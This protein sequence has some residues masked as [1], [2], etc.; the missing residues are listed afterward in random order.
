MLRLL[1]ALA[2]VDSWSFKCLCCIFLESIPIII[3]FILSLNFSVVLSHET[4]LVSISVSFLS[5]CKKEEVASSS[6]KKDIKNNQSQS[7][8]YSTHQ[9]VM[10][11]I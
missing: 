4:S 5:S 10:L 8:M 6:H 9:D 1:L 2:L 3:I 7:N 11:L